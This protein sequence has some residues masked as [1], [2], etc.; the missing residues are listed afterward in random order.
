LQDAI[1]EAGKKLQE[2][3]KVS[4]EGLK[5]ALGKLQGQIAFKLQD[6]LGVST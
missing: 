5:K 2:Q 4:P 1:K 3:M 6:Y